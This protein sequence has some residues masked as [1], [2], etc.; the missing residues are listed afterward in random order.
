MMDNKAHFARVP[1]QLLIDTKPHGH[2]DIHTLLFISGLA[3]KWK[4]EGRK[5]LFIF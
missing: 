5:W 4:E 3:Q 2:G 1:N